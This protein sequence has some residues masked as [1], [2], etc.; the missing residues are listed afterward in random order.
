MTPTAQRL[1]DAWT[2]AHAQWR[3]RSP[4]ERLMATALSAALLV[5]ALWQWTLA[6]AWAVWQQAPQRQAQID[7]QSQRM[8]QLQAQTHALQAAPAMSRQ[9]AVQL[10]QSQARQG[11]GAGSAVQLQ[12]EHV[13]V[14]VQHTSGQALAQW[15]A[16]A[17]T[18]AQA[19][20]LQA[21]LQMQEAPAK[22]LPALAAP[23]SVASLT[24]SL[25][26]AMRPTAGAPAAQDRTAVATTTD[27]PLW[28]GSLV[29][30]LP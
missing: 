10:L 21:S 9:A 25:S 1:K 18:Q 22:P 26:A 2:T 20:V 23:A 29:L 30:R 7:L 13:Q 11:L 15:L 8:R 6:P 5:A 16:L 4:R 17:R 19:S 24:P 3:V 27:G 12:G 28:Q 14:S